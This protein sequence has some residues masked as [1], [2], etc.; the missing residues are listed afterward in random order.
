[1]R[2]E[3]KKAK[4]QEYQA[5]VSKKELVVTLSHDI[6]TPVTSI[7]LMCE[8]MAAKMD[9]NE[10]EEKEFRTKLDSIYAKTEQIDTLVSDMFQST[11]EDLGELRI[12]I[13]EEPS[14]CLKEMLT[15]ADFRGK[16]HTQEDP[17]PCLLV[18]DLLRLEQVIGNVINNSYKYAD[19][20]IEI[21][22]SLE[23]GYLA[24]F[25]RD[26]GEGVS[27]EEL[28]HIFQKFYRGKNALK[29]QKS[30]AGLGLYICGSLME[31]M[32]GSI[33][34]ENREPGF[35]ICIRIALV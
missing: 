17:P 29:V 32:G 13:S 35:C 30:G 34:A 12:A 23:D 2:E 14:N 3:L 26:F 18:A 5:N 16:I 1:M 20:G 33:S 11:L 22:Y 24:L 8:L 21:D 25:I 31:K 10:I 28:P 6:K 27:E 4:E 9:C 7:K 15:R 19:T